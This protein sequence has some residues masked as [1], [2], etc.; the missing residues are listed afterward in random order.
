MSTDRL[1][2]IVVGD[3]I[4]APYHKL[5]DVEDEVK[6]ILSDGM[7][8][9]FTEDRDYFNYEK[10]SEFNICILYVDCWNKKLNEEQMAGLLCFTAVGGR[11]L[12]IHNGISYQSNA[13]FAQMI[14]GKFIKHP[15]YQ[16]LTYNVVKVD[17]PIVQGISAFEMDEELYTFELDNLCDKEI[18]I[19]ATDGNSTAP[20]AWVKSYGK[21]KIVYLAPGHDKKSFK[22]NSFRKL[23]KNSAE[24][25]LA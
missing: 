16:N 3:Y 13:E 25:L 4:D 2:G 15:P 24:W 1:K 12:V 14:G 18:L 17:H 20:A 8:L 5:G 21:G 19:T 6:S 10:L 11:L 23:I 22:N 9:V 7:E